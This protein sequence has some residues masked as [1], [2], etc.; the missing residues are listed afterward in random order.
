MT[1]SRSVVRV[2]R[3]FSLAEQPSDF[4]YWQS[5][6]MEERLEA[7]EALRATHHGWDD[8]TRPRLSR[9]LRRAVR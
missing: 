3:K 9:V 8:E 7:L 2:V 1:Y 6:P 4:A 5:R